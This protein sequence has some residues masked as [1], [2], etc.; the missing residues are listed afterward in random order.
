MAR[1]K[2]I[3]RIRGTLYGLTYYRL[4]GV[5]LV[6]QKSSLDRARVMCDPAFAQSR[7]C[8]GR[9]GHAAR[10]AGIVYRMLPRSGRQ[11]GLIGKLTG[12]A[13]KLLF[14]GDTPDVLEVLL[15][16]TLGPSARER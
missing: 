7:A 8:A 12:L 5:W 6:R 11:H 2:G 10:I 9:F 4:K 15:L 3:T 13:N 16:H 1:Q 14:T